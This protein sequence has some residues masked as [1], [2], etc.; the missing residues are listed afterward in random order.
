MPALNRVQLIGNL[1]RDPESKFTPTGKKV[2]H[3]SIAVSN[4]WKDKSGELKET[5]EWVNIEAWGRL[6]EVCQEYLKKGSLIFIEGRLK[7]DKYESNGETK[8]YTKV[9]A[10]SLQ[11]LD[12]KGKEEPVMAVDEEAGEYEALA[13]E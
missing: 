6:G 2:C 11:F 10:Q 7:T 9:V 5:T 4:R 13:G 12:R 8:Y 3:F 1:G